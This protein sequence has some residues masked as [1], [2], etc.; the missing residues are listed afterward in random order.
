VSVCLSIVCFTFETAERIW[1]KLSIWRKR[2]KMYLRPEAITVRDYK[3]VA[4]VTN[5]VWH[6]SL[7]MSLSRANW[8][9]MKDFGIKCLTRYKGRKVYGLYHW[10]NWRFQFRVGYWITIVKPTRCTNVSNLFYFGMTLYMFQTVF[11][12]IIRSSSLYIQQEA[13]AVC[14]VLLSAC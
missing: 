1:M 5:D 10:I 14:T 13:S 3:I 7:D 12:S 8:N 6:M 11:P 2:I 9:N 4:D